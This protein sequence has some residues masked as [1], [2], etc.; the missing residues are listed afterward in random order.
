MTPLKEN[1]LRR[2]S[3]VFGIMVLLAVSFIAIAQQPAG[4]PSRPSVTKVLGRY[5]MHRPPDGDFFKMTYMFQDTSCHHYSLKLGPHFN[6]INTAG[7]WAVTGSVTGGT[8][9]VEASEEADA[10]T[11]ERANKILGKCPVPEG[12]IFQQ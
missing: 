9:K 5:Y 7:V 8:L 6:Q 11:S 10:A 3:S 12:A 1:C 4:S 2:H